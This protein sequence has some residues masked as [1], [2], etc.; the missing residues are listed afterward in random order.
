LQIWHQVII[1]YTEHS[2][3]VPLEYWQPN[4]LVDATNNQHDY[5]NEE[6]LDMQNNFMYP[7]HNAISNICLGHTIIYHKYQ[8]SIGSVP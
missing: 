4:A 3:G 2:T 1:F 8:Q 5:V 6:E 7:F